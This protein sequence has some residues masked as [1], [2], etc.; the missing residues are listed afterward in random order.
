MEQLE[1]YPSTEQITAVISTQNEDSQ[2]DQIPIDG[3][4]DSQYDQL[5][6]MIKNEAA[7]TKKNLSM[8][9]RER[10]L[11]GKSRVTSSQ[12]VVSTNPIQTNSVN[13]T[14]PELSEEGENRRSRRA[15]CEDSVEVISSG[16]SDLKL[17]PTQVSFQVYF[18]L[19]F[20]F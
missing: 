9:E 15:S 1:E 16:I 17:S 3:T 7:S 8:S 6:L 20:N 18:S 19:T 12:N 11:C 14:L 2:P 5:A 10:A 13:Y 4:L